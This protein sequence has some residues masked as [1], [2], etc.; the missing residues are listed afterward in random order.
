M[1][2]KLKGRYPVGNFIPQDIQHKIKDTLVTLYTD[3]KEYTYII[4][5]NKL[6]KTKYDYITVYTTSHC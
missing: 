1:P 2:M 6:K 4:K 3:L 5:N